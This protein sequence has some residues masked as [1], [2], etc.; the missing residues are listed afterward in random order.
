MTIDN[1]LLKP[2]LKYGILRE[3]M[4]ALMTDAVRAEMLEG[5]GYDTQILEF[6]DIEH[7]PKNLLIRAVKNDS[8]DLGKRKDVVEAALKMEK[9]FNIDLTGNIICK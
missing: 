3:R 1:E 7:T 5:K 2:V 9:E 8:K 4:A 6:I